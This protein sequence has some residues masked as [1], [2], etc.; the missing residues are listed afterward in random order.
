MRE[1]LHNF[2]FFYTRNFD[3]KFNNLILI[4]DNVS[5]LFCNDKSDKF[6]MERSLI[7]ALPHDFCTQ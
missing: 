1:Y 4:F 7:I 5:V 2:A 3:I 6:Y